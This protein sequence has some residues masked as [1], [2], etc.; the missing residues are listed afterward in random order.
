MEYG[1]RHLWKAVVFQHGRVSPQQSGQLAGCGG[2]TVQW[3]HRIGTSCGRF[4]GSTG[5]SRASTRGRDETAWTWREKRRRA[6]VRPGRARLGGLVEVDTTS[7]GGG[8]ESE[9]GTPRP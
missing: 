3:L 7:V 6:R 9:G 8:G 5:G 2:G 4:K 1:R